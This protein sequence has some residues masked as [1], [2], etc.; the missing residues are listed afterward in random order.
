M[1]FLSQKL[2]LHNDSL[3]GILLFLINYDLNNDFYQFKNNL[4][5]LNKDY[6]NFIFIFFNFTNN[7]LV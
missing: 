2:F 7:Y 5:D 1:N 3:I 4:F 6:M